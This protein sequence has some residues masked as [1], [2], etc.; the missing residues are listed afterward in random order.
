MAK[1]HEITDQN[2]EKEVIQSKKNWSLTFSA[3]SYCQPCKIL[4]KTLESEILKDDITNTVNF[5][6]VQVEDKG[7]NIS[8]REGIKGVPTT[9]LYD[10]NGEAIARLV[11]S[12]PANEFL[13]FL[14]KWF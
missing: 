10:K 2:F 13:A 12:V 5:G 7:L 4:H 11:G 14:R 9:I 6:T 8:S 1:L 3:L